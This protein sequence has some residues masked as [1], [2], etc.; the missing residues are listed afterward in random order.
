MVVYV[1]EMFWVGVSHA[2]GAMLQL[3][4]LQTVTLSTKTRTMVTLCKRCGLTLNACNYY[5]YQ[6]PLMQTE[7]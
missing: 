4:L 3:R 7:C 6:F 2:S 5:E 1:L